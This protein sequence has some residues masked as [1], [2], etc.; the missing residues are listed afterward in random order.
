MRLG[1]PHGWVRFTIQEVINQVA[2][3]TG[4][5]RSSDILFGSCFRPEDEMACP[6]NRFQGIPYSPHAFHDVL[7]A[8]RIGDPNVPFPRRTER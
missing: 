5:H 4:G 6:L 2:L 3:E 1:R 7:A 8:R